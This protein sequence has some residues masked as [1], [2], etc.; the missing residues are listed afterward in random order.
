MGNSLT[1]PVNSQVCVAQR[2][3]IKFDARLLLKHFHRQVGNKSGSTCPFAGK[4]TYFP[5]HHEKHTA[6]VQL[7]QKQNTYTFLSDFLNEVWL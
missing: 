7:A 3:A 2:I 5:K 4:A 1:L 6:N